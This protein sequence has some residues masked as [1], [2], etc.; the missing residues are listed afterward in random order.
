MT[1]LS[2]ILDVVDEEGN[3]SGGTVEREKA[4]REGIRHRTSH[5]WIVREKDGRKQVL[6]QKRSENKDSFP[7]EWDIS[8]AGHIPAGCGWKESAV[9][10][11]REELGVQA[12]E[13]DLQKIGLLRIQSDEDFHGH[14]FHDRQVTTLFLLR[15]DWDESRFT[16]QK[17]ELSEVRWFDLDRVID[18]T[19]AGR[20]GICLNATELEIVREHASDAAAAAQCRPVSVTRGA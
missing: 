1:Q 13:D 4:H 8:S 19:M 17:E 7:G 2:E 20:M 5:V 18:D 14:P 15:L 3:P 10:E 6:L 12:S 16:P 11:L 9:R